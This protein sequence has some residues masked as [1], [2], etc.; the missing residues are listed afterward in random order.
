MAALDHMDTRSYGSARES[1]IRSAGGCLPFYATS[2]P[3]AWKR[4]VQKSDLLKRRVP[5]AVMS[6]PHAR[7][8]YRQGSVGGDGPRPAIPY[9]VPGPLPIATHRL[10]VYTLRYR[11]GRTAGWVALNP[12]HHPTYS[13]STTWQAAITTARKVEKNF[14][15][16]PAPFHQPGAFQPPRLQIAL[17]R[18]L[19][20]LDELPAL[21]RNAPAEVLLYLE[22]S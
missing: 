9:W 21:Y 20:N 6:D 17:N 19:E 5:A 7:T 1:T 14:V 2:T 11:R 15:S 18:V 13:F 22:P 12:R 4:P 8:D 3:R 16:R 10:P